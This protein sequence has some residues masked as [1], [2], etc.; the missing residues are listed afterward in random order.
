[1]RLLALAA[2]LRRESLSRKHLQLAVDLAMNAGIEVDL[3]DFHD[4]DM[5]LY[6]AD[7]QTA[8]GFPR[9]ARELARRIDSADGLLIAWY[10]ACG[11]QASQAFAEAGK[12][13]DQDVRDRLVKMV[14]GYL[15]MGQ[16]LPAL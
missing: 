7:L 8:S 10:A 5:L 1:M 11:G 14:G 12:L 3:A 13:K 6:D 9:G 4:F 15:V 16:K 2:S